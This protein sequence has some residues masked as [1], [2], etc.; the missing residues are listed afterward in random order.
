MNEELQKMLLELKGMFDLQTETAVE[1]KK[2]MDA[3]EA[4]N[5]EIVA[6]MS[7]IQIKSR[8]G[9]GNVEQKSNYF[10]GQKAARLM[11]VDVIR[12]QKGNEQKSMSEIATE[13]WGKKDAAFVEEVKNIEIERKG[14]NASGNAGTLIEEGYFAE[15]IPLLYNKLAVK[16]AGA[17]IVPMPKGNL[18]I[19]KM[20]SG[21]TASWVGEAMAK[22]A[23]KAMFGKLKLVAKKLIVKTVYS[24]DLLRSDTVGADAIILDDLVMQL[25]IAL[26]YAAFYGKGTEYTPLGIANMKGVKI[27][28][29]TALGAVLD[30]D[31]CYKFFV[32]PLKEANIPMEKMAWIIPPR[33][34]TK[35]YNETFANGTYKYRDELKQGKFHGYPLIETNQIVID[36]ANTTDEP[37][38]MFFGDFAQFYIGEQMGLEVRESEDASYLDENGVTQSAFDN[39]ETVVRALMICDMGAVHPKAFVYGKALKTK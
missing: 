26:D 35:F 30:G 1:Q 7:E 38:D 13:I 31:A 34:F 27:V 24:N 17:K 10:V 33:A 5:T 8:F 37:T 3:I 11:R 12:S 39:D 20:V 18:N 19:R 9:N 6:A 4:K 25:Q 15:V 28:D 16:L 22:N 14:L 36:T 29:Q 32:Q 21:T 2:K 23:T